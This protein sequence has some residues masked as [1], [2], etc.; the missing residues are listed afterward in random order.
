MR[1]GRPAVFAVI[2]LSSFSAWAA[3]RTFVSGSGNDANPCT[4]DMPCR[5]FGAAIA[6]TSTNGEVVA[7]DSAGYGPV[8]VTQGV[9]IVAPNGVHAGISVFSGDGVT[10]NASGGVVVLRNLYINSQGGTNGITLT[11]AATLHIEHCVVSGF[12]NNDINLVPTSAATVEIGDT[13]TRQG[14]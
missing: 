13:I 6:V 7:L 1:F 3:Q 2:V 12:S 11:T 9:A 8:T 10:V 4:R 5:S 14:G